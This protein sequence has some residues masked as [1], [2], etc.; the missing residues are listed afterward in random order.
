VAIVAAVILK[1]FDGVQ[2]DIRGDHVAAALVDRLL[3]DRRPGRQ[4]VGPIE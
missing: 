2:E 1:R 4:L 3:F